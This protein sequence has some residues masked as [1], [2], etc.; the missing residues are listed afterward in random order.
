MGGF[1]ADCC[2]ALFTFMD[3]YISALCVGLGFYRAEDTAALVRSVTGVYINVEGAEA[4]GTMVSRGIAE[5]QDLF[6]AIFADKAVI[7]FGKAFCFHIYLPTQNFENMSET[8]SSDIALPSSS[9]I[10]PSASSTS[11]DAASVEIPSS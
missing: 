10:A 3:Y 2:A 4:K 8:T 6:A 1:V 11:D 7:V 9:A 5:G